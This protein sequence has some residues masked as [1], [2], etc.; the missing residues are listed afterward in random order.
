MLPFSGAQYGR[1]ESG[2]CHL[3]NALDRQRALHRVVGAMVLPSF[4]AA[5]IRSPPSEHRANAE[6]WTG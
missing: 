3:A 2:W 5:T 1:S 4:P 6:P